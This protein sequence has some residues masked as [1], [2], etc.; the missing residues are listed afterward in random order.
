MSPAMPPSGQTRGCRGSSFTEYR[1]V[2][3]Y[4]K[5]AGKKNDSAL[6]IAEI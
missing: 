6:T 4:A 5:Q 3:T 1:P 2:R